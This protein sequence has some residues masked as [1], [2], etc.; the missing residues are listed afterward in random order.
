MR[1]RPQGKKKGRSL[2]RVSLEL[3]T[4]LRTLPGAEPSLG[5]DPFTYAAML[6]L[7]LGYQIAQTQ[8]EEGK[9]SLLSAGSEG[10][11]GRMGQRPL[12][13]GIAERQGSRPGSRSDSW[14]DREG[15]GDNRSYDTPGIGS[16]RGHTRTQA[17]DGIREWPGYN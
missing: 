3:G 15:R 16:V 12:P 8:P 10:G 2:K 6:G 11:G 5:S 14:P 9:I 7:W 1:L 4:V 13:L 17:I